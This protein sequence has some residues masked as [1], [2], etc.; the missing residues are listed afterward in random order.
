MKEKVKNDFF[1]LYIKTK[2]NSELL[3]YY[4]KIF[5]IL[6]YFQKYYSRLFHFIRMKNYSMMYVGKHEE[7][8]HLRKYY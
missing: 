3:N 7:H 5:S 6:L 4:R 2:I 8:F 1:I